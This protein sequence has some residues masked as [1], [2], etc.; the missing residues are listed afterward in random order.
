[1]LAFVYFSTTFRHRSLIITGFKVKEILGSITSDLIVYRVFYWKNRH[2]IAY[3]V[4]RKAL[5]LDRVCFSFILMTF[6]TV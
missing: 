4:C 6:L 2:Q 1:M 5:F 3:M